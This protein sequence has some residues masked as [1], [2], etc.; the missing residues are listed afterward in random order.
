MPPQDQELF[1]K[2]VSIDAEDT[3]AGVRAEKDFIARIC[4]ERGKDWKMEHQSLIEHNGKPYDIIV[5]A[6]SSGETKTFY[7]EIS[8]FFGK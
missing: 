1:D 6:L 8:K 4:G 3:L 7:F 5:V 2:A